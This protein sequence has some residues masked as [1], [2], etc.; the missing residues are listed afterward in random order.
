MNGTRPLHFF[1]EAQPRPCFERAG[2]QPE[3]QLSTVPSSTEEAVAYFVQEGEPVGKEQ[4]GGGAAPLLPLT[5]GWH[6]AS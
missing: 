2:L 6:G 1:F 4:V 3:Q 5:L